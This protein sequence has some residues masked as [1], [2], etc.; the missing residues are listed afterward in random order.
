MNI[1]PGH[2]GKP[3]CLY[4]KKNPSRNEKRESGPT[5][6]NLYSGKTIMEELEF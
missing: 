2:V 5:P 4:Q 1:W 3:L 6:N